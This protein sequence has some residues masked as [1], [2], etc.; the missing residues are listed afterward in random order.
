MSLRA[1]FDK[2]ELQLVRVL[3]TVITERSVSR[4]ALRLHSSQPAVSAQLRR[5]RA[6]TGDALL[7]R[8]GA[9]MTPT[10]AALELLEPAGRLLQEAESLFGKH[11]RLS[12][13]SGFDPAT[14]ALR[15]RI[16]ASDYLDP[17]FLPELVA[18][19]QRSAPGVQ[20]D[21]QPLSAEYD[22][23]RSLARGEVDLVIGNWLKPPDELHLGRLLSDE[24][25]CLVGS[26]HPLARSNGRGWTVEKY[27]ACQH[28]AP[29]PL[30]PGQPG[31]IDE[32]LA[33]LGLARAIA[34]RSAHFGQLPQMVASSLLVLT[35]GRL[36]CSR[37]LDQLP[38][39]ILRCPVAFPTMSYYQLWHELSH[40]APPMRWLREQ[41]RDVARML[42]AQAPK[43]AQ[44]G[45][46]D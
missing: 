1:D 40:A 46:V 38:V 30:S 39:K 34:V 15:F 43:A 16:A 24:V 27:L 37:Y 33:G 42:V 45:S 3:H 18:Q 10:P 35:T 44:L 36:F 22:Y 21:L 14:A 20:L 9:G 13:V 6:L 19:L 23:R 7:V 28:L 26:E 25:V 11:G 12:R 32:H 41:V 17:L 29:M 8:S 31:V 2:I 4:A 5:L